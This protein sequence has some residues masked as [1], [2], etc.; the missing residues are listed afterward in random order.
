MTSY[1]RYPRRPTRP[2]TPVRYWT[3]EDD[4]LGTIATEDPRSPH[5]PTR[6]CQANPEHVH[7]G[8]AVRYSPRY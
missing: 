4:R 8:R 1:S 2:T 7:I 6:A 3:D 5:Y